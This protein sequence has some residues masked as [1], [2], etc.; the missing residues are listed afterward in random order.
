MTRL[1]SIPSSNKEPEGP[2]TDPPAAEPLAEAG[3]VPEAEALSSPASVRTPRRWGRW[4]LSGCALLLLLAGGGFGWLYWA[5]QQVP[6][7]YEAVSRQSEDIPVEKV[8]ETAARVT[9]QTQA[10]LDRE[11]AEKNNWTFDITPLELNAWLMEELPRLAGGEWPDE[12]DDLRIA[13][14]K[15]RI[16][17]GVKVSAPPWTGVA[18][19]SLLPKLKAPRT[20]LLEVESLKMGNVPLPVD[21]LVAEV[22]ELARSPYVRRDSESG[23]YVVRA[24][25]DSRE[26]KGLLLE[27]LDLTPERLRLSGR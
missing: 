22:P 19:L 23:R 10:V 13:F 11:P 9:R 25:L 8:R 17:L 3:A 12:L 27:R 5:S 4:L 6:D 14:E 1:S 18:S 16:L 20:I 26:T 21:R 7:F 2:A 24:P 15:E